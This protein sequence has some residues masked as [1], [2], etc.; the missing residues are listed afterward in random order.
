MQQSALKK[1]PGKIMDE[2]IIQELPLKVRAKKLADLF[3]M[4]P[5][6]PV[7][8]PTSAFDEEEQ[9]GCRE[10]LPDE[11]SSSSDSSQKPLSCRTAEP[12]E[13]GINFQGRYC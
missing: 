9:D 6:P 1:T 8:F 7:T 10:G 12:D 5:S 4:I 11:D 13:S 3:E 2:P